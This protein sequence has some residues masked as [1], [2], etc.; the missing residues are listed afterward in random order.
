MGGYLSNDFTIY[1]RRV[2]TDKYELVDEL[3]EGSPMSRFK[4]EVYAFGLKRKHQTLKSMYLYCGNTR[5]VKCETTNE[6]GVL[7][8]LLT[9]ASTESAFQWDSAQEQIRRVYIDLSWLERQFS[10]HFVEMN[11][12]NMFQRRYQNYKMTLSKT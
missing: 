3:K 9:F 5:I 1:G 11:D 2:D 10:S 7:Y 4:H 6:Q 8:I 12:N